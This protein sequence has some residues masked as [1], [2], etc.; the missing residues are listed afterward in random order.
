MTLLNEHE[1]TSNLIP[2]KTIVDA[3]SIQSQLCHLCVGQVAYK[4]MVD[5]ILQSVTHFQVKHRGE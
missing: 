1:I 4:C 3:K 5:Y 2:S